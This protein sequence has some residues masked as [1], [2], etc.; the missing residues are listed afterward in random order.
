MSVEQRIRDYI[1]NNYLFTDDPSALDSRD[2]F[3]ERGIIDSTGIMEV[4]FFLEQEF[5][6]RVED[7]EMTPENLDSV[8]SIV[9]F[10]G[11]KRAAA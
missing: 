10:I 4:I 5:G 9:R 8:N 6:V 1:L 2:S 3:L 7:D 11:R